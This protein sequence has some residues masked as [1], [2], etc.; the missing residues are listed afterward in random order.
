MCHISCISF[1]VDAR[2]LAAS[3]P[4]TQIMMGAIGTKLRTL[5][6]FGVRSRKFSQSGKV[7]QSHFI[8]AF[9]ESNGI[10]S[11]RDIV[12]IARSR[13][14]G[15]QGAKP[16]P[17]LPSTSEVTPCQLDNVQYGSQLI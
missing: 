13:S 2:L 14:S 6:P 10:A 4:I 11:T 8:P 3:K 1:S 15:L 17:Q 5:S 16:K 9:I 7:T 12:S